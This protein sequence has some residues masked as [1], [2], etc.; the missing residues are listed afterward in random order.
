[1][2]KLA[3][4][5]SALVFVS[6]SFAMAAGV[7]QLAGDYQLVDSRVVKGTTK[8]FNRIIIDIQGTQAEVTSPELAAY[9]PSTLFKGDINGPSNEISGGHGEAGTSYKGQQSVKFE[10]GI[11]TFATKANMKV[12]GIPS[13]TSTETFIVEPTKTAGLIKVTYKTFEGVVGIGDRTEALC[14]YQKN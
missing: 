8:C 9:G 4:V 5:F 3:F 6:T 14:A 11:L 12:L 1:M 2:T 13:G 10:N 7:N